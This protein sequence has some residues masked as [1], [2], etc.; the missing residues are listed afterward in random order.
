MNYWEKGDTYGLPT[1]YGRDHPDSLITKL[2]TLVDVTNREYA[3]VPYTSSLGSPHIDKWVSSVFFG[4]NCV[5]IT[6]M[7]EKE[8]A[9][10][11]NR[12]YR[13]K[14]TVFK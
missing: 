3:K 2:K 5:V 9:M 11:G 1:A 12:N 14:D 13:Y 4:H 10:Y 8:M 7:S 6:K